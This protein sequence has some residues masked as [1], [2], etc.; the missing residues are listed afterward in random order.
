MHLFDQRI[1]GIAIVCL[2]GALVAV[3]RIATGSILDAPKGNLMVQIVNVFNL[4]FLLVVNPFAAVALLA[5]GL[6]MLDPTHLTIQEPRILTVVELAGLALYVA[7]FLLMAWALIVLGSNYQLGGSVPRSK[8]E[9]VNNGPYALIRHPMYTSA[10]SIA[11]GLAC[12]TQSWAFLAVTCI[13]V[14]LI[15]PMISMEEAGLRVAYGERYG[16]YL[17]HTKKLIPFIY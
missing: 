15:L 10:M 16:A 3:K 1:L 12:L 14:A 11:L 13:Y 6:P 8:D 4:F 2:L 5:R 7:G 9:M 17:N